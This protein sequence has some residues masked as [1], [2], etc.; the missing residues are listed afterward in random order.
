MSAKLGAVSVGRD[1]TDRSAVSDALA[2]A[3]DQEVTGNLH[4]AYQSAC[5]ILGRQG[6][7]MDPDRR[8]SQGSGDDEPERAGRY[9]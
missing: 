7:L 4:E 8:P 1:L 5:R 2:A 9:C 6:A 3:V